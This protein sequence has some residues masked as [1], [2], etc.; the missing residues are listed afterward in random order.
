MVSSL[1][2]IAMFVLGA[3]AYIYLDDVDMVMDDGDSFREEAVE[4]VGGATLIVAPF[5]LVAAF[6]TATALA[7][8]A[9]R[10]LEDAIKAARGTSAH[11]LRRSLPVPEQDGELRDL[12]VSLN[13]LFLRLDDGFGALAS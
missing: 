7:R 2:T 9:A 4:L 3:L 5:V 6:V 11:D 10:P 13:D 12:V 8:R 1:A